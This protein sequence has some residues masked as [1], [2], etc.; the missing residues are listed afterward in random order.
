MIDKTQ[1]GIGSNNSNLN[2]AVNPVKTINS[3]EISFKAVFDQ[4]LRN[5]SKQQLQLSK[6][7]KDRIAQRGIS[8]DQDMMSSLNNA[9]D[10]ARSKGSR[11]IVMIG[12][13]AAFVV[14]IPNGVIVTA[15]SSDEMKDNIFTNIDSAVLI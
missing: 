1:I 7:A 2:T 14:N 6:H 15:V 4:Q 8:I 3:Q 11:D 5:E 9:A 13:D 10:I 12:K